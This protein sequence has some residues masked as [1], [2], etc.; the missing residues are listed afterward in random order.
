MDLVQDGQITVLDARKN[1][2]ILL[3][4]DIGLWSVQRLRVA[5]RSFRLSRLR[6]MMRRALAGSTFVECFQPSAAETPEP[7]F[8]A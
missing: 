6:R 3:I 5:R 4:G 8:D 2:P 7:R 1:V